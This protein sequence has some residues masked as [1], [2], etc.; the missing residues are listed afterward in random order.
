MKA[1]EEESLIKTITTTSY[2]DK[3]S[4]YFTNFQ[5]FFAKDDVQVASQHRFGKEAQDMELVREKI[6]NSIQEGRNAIMEDVQRPDKL[7]IPV[8]CNIPPHRQGKRERQHVTIK[9]IVAR[10]NNSGQEVV[11]LTGTQEQLSSRKPSDLLH[12]ITM[13][14]LRFREDVRP[15]YMGTFTK[16]PSGTSART[17][18]RNPFKR[19]IPQL[20]YDYDSEVE[21]EEP[22]PEDGEDLGSEDEEAGSEGDEDEMEGFLD[23]EE[24]SGNSAASNKRRLVV[25]DLK[26]AC[27]G[28]CWED[29]RGH[30]QWNESEESLM[31]IDM[32]GYKLEIMKGNTQL[33]PGNA[34]L[35]LIK[36]PQTLLTYPSILMRRHIGTV[37]LVR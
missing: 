34:A 8:L 22:D 13:K 19:S 25:G 29:H 21:W 9:E 37:Q 35:L 24:T 27:T 3:S 18:C 1:V 15:P 4:E 36:G 20:N 12:G 16:K 31:K 26:P 14:Y 7:N 6:D 30:P 2:P 28:L 32:S 10:M 17:L 33:H 11:D 23:D 5:P